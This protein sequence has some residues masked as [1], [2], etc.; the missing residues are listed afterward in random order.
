M[1]FKYSPIMPWLVTGLLTGLLAL[2]G[3]VLP[4]VRF[5]V[6]LVWAVPVVYL[7]RRQGLRQGSLAIL[8]ASLVVSLAAGASNGLIVILEIGSLALVMGLL[9]KNAVPAQR[10]MLYSVVVAVV[11]Q[12]ML[13]GVT[14]NQ[15]TSDNQEV[16]L[17]I[18]KQ[19][20]EI[21]TMFKE[22]GLV[23][24]AGAPTEE[25]FRQAFQETWLLTL[26]LASGITIITAILM[27]LANYQLAYYYLARQRQ[28]LPQHLPL[29]N[30]R[31]PWYTI[32]GLITGLSLLL[33]GNGSGIA[34]VLGKNIVLVS[35]FGGLLLGLAVLSYYFSKKALPKML[36]I[37]LVLLIVFYLPLALVLL[38]LIGIF[39]PVV[40]FRRIAT[41]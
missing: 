19:Q 2:A 26:Q 3:Y 40:N 1:S 21:L 7:V 41:Q 24:T 6:S 13:L 34:D 39:D 35:L 10:I 30:W 28:A 11:M 17:Q 27:A 4:E 32:W 9:Y 23:G 31:F 16:K 38:T 29:A 15:L 33:L 8:L 36:K 22:V 12:L 20:T 37:S 25:E 18:E 5:F 14:I